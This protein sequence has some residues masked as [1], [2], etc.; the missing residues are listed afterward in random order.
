MLIVLLLTPHTASRMKLELSRKE[1]SPEVFVHGH[2]LMAELSRNHADA[3]WVQ[4]LIA[5]MLV[6]HHTCRLTQRHDAPCGG[7]A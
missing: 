3:R 7:M 2:R 4:L 5:P 6:A 1:G